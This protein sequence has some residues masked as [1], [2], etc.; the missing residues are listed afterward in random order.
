[1]SLLKSKTYHFY[2][3][4]SLYRGKQYFLVNKLRIECIGGESMTEENKLVF[5]E[6]E[7]IPRLLRGSQGRNWVELFDKIPEGKVLAMNVE[8]YGSSPNIRT[9]AKLYN[10][11]KN[12][13]V[14]KA[15]Q[16]TDKKT[17]EITVYVQRIA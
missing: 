2:K 7:D 8:D 16:R 4:K 11:D 9:Q 1:M 13:K 5:L 17:E 6:P 3:E 15:T 14:L 12:K 10:K